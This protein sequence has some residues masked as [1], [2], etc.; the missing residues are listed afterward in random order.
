[1]QTLPRVLSIVTTQRLGLQNRAICELR[2][3]GCKVLRVSLDA[4]LTLDVA[5]G[6]FKAI[7]PHAHGVLTRQLD[8]QHEQVSVG[9]AG[10][11]VRWIE[12]MR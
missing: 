1:V 5:P 4:S 2:A 6:C 12:E 8:A 7:R 11:T 10:C 9:F 3:L